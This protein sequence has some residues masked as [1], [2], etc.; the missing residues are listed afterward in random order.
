MAMTLA[1]ASLLTNSMLLRGVIETVYSESAVLKY[2]PFMEVI[3]SSLAYPQETA[4]PAMQFNAVGGTWSE[5]APT[6]AQSTETLKIL[7]GDSDVDNYLARSFTQEN[8]I[9]S[10]VVHEKAKALAYTF[11]NYFFTG[12]TGVDANG[13]DGVDKRIGA[14]AAAQ[15]IT[16]GTNG[17]ALTLAMMDQVIDAVKPGRPDVLFMSRRSRRNLN[18]LRRA[19]GN[20]LQAELDQFGQ[21]VLWYDGIPVEIDDFIPDNKAVGTSGNICSTIYALKF[22]WN[23]G[24]MGIHS[25]G[26]QVDRFGALET[27]DATRNR[28]KFYCSIALM[29]PIGT[30]RLIGVNGN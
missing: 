23:T 11:S 16:A 8:D 12:D 24:V 5:G 29:N 21:M 3:G 17:A 26:I 13:F 10:V 9:E 14:A 1:Q 20:I 28:L 2:L 18:A 22:G 4:L 27:K 30:A 6:F 7:G 19:A 25:G 15:T